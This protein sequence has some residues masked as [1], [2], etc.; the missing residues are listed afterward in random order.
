M[1]SKENLDALSREI[2]EAFPK[3][4]PPPT[5]NL[6][7]HRCPECDGVRDDF[8]GVEWWAAENKLLD[9]NYDDLPLFTPEA[10]H[11]Y[12]PAFLL[13]SLDQFEDD[14]SVLQFTIYSLS[15]TKTPTDD[16]RYR[17]RLSWFTPKQ[18]AAISGFLKCVLADEELYNYYADAE[19]GLQKFWNT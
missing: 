18:V 14:S 4:T 16:P 7:S 10:F 6:T 11:Y 5:E 15:P 8:S 13:R 3:L 9:D 1:T 17:E 19:R 2:L 12:L